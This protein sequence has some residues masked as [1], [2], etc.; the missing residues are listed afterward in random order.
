M[1]AIGDRHINAL[2]IGRG[3]PLNPSERSSWANWRAPHDVAVIGIE[4]PKDAA[5]L[6]EADDISY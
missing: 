2:A 1:V 6:T 3:A 4:C 5:L